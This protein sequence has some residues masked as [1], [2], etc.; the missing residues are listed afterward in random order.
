VYLNACRES[1]AEQEC[2]EEE[3]CAYS[4]LAAPSSQKNFV[5]G[6]K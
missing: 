3:S 1:E 5:S 2:L 4:R 6:L